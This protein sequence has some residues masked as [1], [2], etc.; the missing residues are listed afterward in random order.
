MDALFSD[1]YDAKDNCKDF[2]NI[3]IGIFPLSP[4]QFY[5]RTR[6]GSLLVCAHRGFIPDYGHCR[7]NHSKI[8]LIHDHANRDRSASIID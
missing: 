2:P 7:K 8:A 6:K 4:V 3:C 5:R 1:E